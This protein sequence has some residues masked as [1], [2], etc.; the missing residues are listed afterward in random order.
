MQVHQ[1]IKGRINI[2]AADFLKK[3]LGLNDKEMAAYLGTS[4]ATLQR[5]RQKQQTISFVQGDR[6]SRMARLLAKAEQLFGNSKTASEWLKSPQ[7][8]FGGK[9]PF[10]L[11]D[12]EAGA[13]EVED[14]L[15]RM[16]HG[17][18]S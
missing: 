18:I 17:V 10:D 6:L 1:A 2:S 13:R 9:I 11:M 14:L 12:T 16:Q 5:K 3:R 15:G 4:P 7:R 8:G